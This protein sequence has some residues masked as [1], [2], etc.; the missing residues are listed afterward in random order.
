MINMLKDDEDG[1]GGDYA[2]YQRLRFK[3]NNRK[4]ASSK[5]TL[6]LKINP[7]HNGIRRISAQ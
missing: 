4:E 5:L 1:V 7:Q 6:S 3:G 2:E